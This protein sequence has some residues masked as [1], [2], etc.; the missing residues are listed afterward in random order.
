MDDTETDMAVSK[1]VRIIY[2]MELKWCVLGK[3]FNFILLTS[4]ADHNEQMGRLR[5]K[6]A[7]DVEE[8]T[9]EWEPGDR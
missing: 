9:V 5:F 6:A 8:G 4:F 1:Y 2:W 7:Q 3:H